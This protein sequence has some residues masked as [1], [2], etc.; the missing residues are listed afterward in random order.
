MS[1]SDELGVL[2]Q[3]LDRR[4]RHADLISTTGPSGTVPQHMSARSRCLMTAAALAAV[5]ALAGGCGDQG[6]GESPAGTGSVTAVK[7]NGDA[8]GASTPARPGGVRLV[9]VAKRSRRATVSPASLRR[10]IAVMRRRVELLGVRGAD[11]RRSGDD[12]IIVT[13][14][15]VGSADQ[16]QQVVGTTANLGFYDWEASVLGPHGKR[17]P[18][19]AVVTGG[20]SAGQ[21]DAGT[22]T[23]YEAV[24]RASKLEPT[25]EP[26]D[27][28]T[29]LFYGVDRK[30]RSVLCGP[31][32]S[33]A[34]ARETCSKAGKEPT[35][36]V[37]VPRGRLIVRAEADDGD[38]VLQAAA[39]DAYYILNDDPA[40][41]GR[42]LEDPE[43]QTDDGPGGSGQPDITFTFT[44][45]GAQ[46]WETMTR[47]IAKRGQ[48]AA[49]PGTDPRS[50]ANH[51]AIIMDN[52]LISV[53]YIDPQQNPDGIDGAN[54]SQISGGFTIKSAQRLAILIKTGALPIRL[55]LISSSQVK[56]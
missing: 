10:T 39:S 7:T 32:G 43:Q 46:K 34:D 21:P 1:L 15:D 8:G 29:D 2:W 31:Q 6:R 49:S 4:A 30:A 12:Q 23:F 27:T 56:P 35:S 25:D 41:L 48:S 26:D 55:E 53:P 16:A 52:K 45:A 18:T 22:Q 42:D 20:S 36:I 54:G 13:L 24:T 11:I 38:K 50:V 3:P 17:D 33:K 37:K 51:F 5:G 44:A 40:L 19:D 47:A 28:T 14:P 9:Y